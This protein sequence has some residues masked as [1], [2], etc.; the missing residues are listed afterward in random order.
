MRI[1]YTRVVGNIREG[2]VRCSRRFILALTLPP[3]D[4]IR[5][6]EQLLIRRKCRYLIAFQEKLLN[7]QFPLLLLTHSSARQEGKLAQA[8]LMQVRN[9]TT[10]FDVGDSFLPAEV[11]WSSAVMISLSRRIPRGDVGVEDVEGG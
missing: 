11:R 1:G 10:R 8:Q 5:G 9:T 3:K 4:N 6:R 7:Q 2:L